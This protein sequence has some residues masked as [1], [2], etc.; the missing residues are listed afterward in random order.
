[1]DFSDTASTVRPVAPVARVASSDRLRFAIA[2]MWSAE[3]TFVMYRR[4]VTRV[5]NAVG[6]KDVFVI[7]PSYAALREALDRQ[8]VDVA[9]VC[10]GP[11]VC[12]LGGGQLK[13]LVQPEFEPGLVYRSVLLTPIDR[14]VRGLGG[15]R[16]ATLAFSDPESFTGCFVPY[17]ELVQMGVEPQTFLKRIVFTG[18]HER[19]IEAVR[20]GLVDAAAVHSIVWNSWKRLHP[21]LANRLTENWTSDVFGPPPVVVP[22]DLAP[23]LVD[24][25][26]NAFLALDADEDGRQI[27]AALAIKRFVRGNPEDYRSATQLYA[28][29]RASSGMPP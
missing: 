16:G 17:M 4:L 12:S 28:R 24:G 2:T 9:V 13:L 19:S 6:R 27:L 21:P 26:R 8:E 22:A 11:Y 5:A 25:L 10:T 29:F 23:E 3:S 20:T 14:P 18:N 15:L 1:V 7:R